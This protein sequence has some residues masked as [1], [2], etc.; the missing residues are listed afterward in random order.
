M[1]MGGIKKN[2]VA[3]AMLKSDNNMDSVTA[4]TLSGNPVPIGREYEN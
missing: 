4:S 1:A 2:I 3:G